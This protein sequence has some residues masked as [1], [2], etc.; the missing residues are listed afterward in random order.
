MFAV[1]KSF[2]AII[3]ASRGNQHRQEESFGS[4]MPRPQYSLSTGAIRHRSPMHT[5]TLCT[6]LTWESPSNMRNCLK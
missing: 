6:I 4:F 3:V 5:T 1:S 2:G